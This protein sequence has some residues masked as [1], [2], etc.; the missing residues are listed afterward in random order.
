MLP[1]TKALG[2]G[3]LAAGGLLG[4]ALGSAFDAPRRAMTNLL[5]TPALSGSIP[6]MPFSNQVRV[7]MVPQSGLW[8]MAKQELDPNYQPPEVPQVTERSP[9]PLSMLPGAIGIG[10]GILAATN[11]VTAPFAGLIGA[12]VAGLGQMAGEALDPESYAAP[13]TD[14]LVRAMGQDPDSLKGVGLSVGLGTLLDPL[15]Y[16]GALGGARGG[17]ALGGARDVL[18]DRAV[19]MEQLAQ[20]SGQLGE[21]QQLA[22]L[23]EQRYAKPLPAWQQQMLA[24]VERGPGMT[25]RPDVEA[26]MPNLLSREV[27]QSKL[28][29]QI[30][31]ALAQ[32][33]HY[34]GLGL[35]TPEGGME[36]TAGAAPDWARARGGWLKPTAAR[37]E[38]LA[39][40]TPT[41]MPSLQGPD[42]PRD[43]GMLSTLQDPLADWQAMRQQ[44]GWGP[45]PA[46]GPGRM[47]SMMDMLNTAEQQQVIGNPSA[48]IPD[49]PQQGSIWKDPT[50]GVL[51][52]V[53]D[54]PLDQVQPRLQQM[55]TGNA[56]QMQGLLDTPLTPAQ[57]L[58][59]ALRLAPG[60]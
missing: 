52:N 9:S 1:S 17:A 25:Y 23:A 4:H 50:R 12:G 28:Y 53:A 8:E 24:D 36:M 16:V 5:A 15:T 46:G 7:D 11:P 56:N 59:A 30:D 41:A 57:K 39:G 47:P 22:G 44:A 48:M 42:L 29:K 19:Q 26:S 40:G 60:A 55:L 3:G 14:Q 37:E 58:L 45:P 34:T 21:L 18:A 51:G 27:A 13:S 38:M 6:D 49:F 10:S 20:Q 35:P 2:Y 43:R 32:D 31:P 33:L 54:L